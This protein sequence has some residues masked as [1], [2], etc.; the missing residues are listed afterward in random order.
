MNFKTFEQ[1]SELHGRLLGKYTQKLIDGNISVN[2][3]LDFHKK[4]EGSLMLFAT[5]FDDVNKFEE[6][7]CENYPNADIPPQKQVEH[8]I[9]HYNIGIKHGLK[10]MTFGLLEANDK[11]RTHQPVLIYHLSK[12]CRGW[13]K[14]K[15]L[16]YIKD[17]Y[18]GVSEPSE[19]D[20]R[21]IE[22][23]RRLGI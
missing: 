9:E 17:S 21:T 19:S 16:S 5:T 3:Y 6:Y 12:N 8:E 15:L 18:E 14:E 4:I 20:S 2:Q 1:V 13:D 23:L 7:F 11:E 10:E 22:T